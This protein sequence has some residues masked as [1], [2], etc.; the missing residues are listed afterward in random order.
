MTAQRSSLGGLMARLHVLLCPVGSTGDLNPMLGIGVELRRRGHDVTLLGTE[1]YREPTVATGLEFFA[2]QDRETE[3]RELQHADAWSYRNGRRRH[4]PVRCL[5]TLRR[6][7]DAI[8]ARRS[9]GR[10]V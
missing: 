5:E 2:V 6:T 3:S 4:I 10:T 8:A 9:A 1:S 7:Y